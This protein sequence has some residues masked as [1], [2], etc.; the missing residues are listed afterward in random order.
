MAYR[1]VRPIGD[2]LLEPWNEKAESFLDSDF[3]AG[4]KYVL[5]RYVSVHP[6]LQAL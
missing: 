5:A 1:E 4:N 3:L 6:L 2:A